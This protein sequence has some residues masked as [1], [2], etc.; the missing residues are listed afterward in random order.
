VQAGALD[1]TLAARTIARLLTIGRDALRKADSV[2]VVAI[3]GGVTLLIE[4]REIV[5]AFQAMIR[6][7]TPGSSSPG[8]SGP[9]RTWWRPSP[10][11]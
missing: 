4:A 6:K 10:T 2:T 1:R 5:A 8:W 9:R 7:K 3:E 11:G